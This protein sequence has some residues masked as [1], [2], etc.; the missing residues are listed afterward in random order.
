MPFPLRE[1]QD[2]GERLE[3]QVQEDHL[4]LVERQEKEVEQ[5]L[6]VHKVLQVQMDSLELTESV[7]HVGS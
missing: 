5:E 6:Q 1:N 7:D 2:L 3:K 4:D